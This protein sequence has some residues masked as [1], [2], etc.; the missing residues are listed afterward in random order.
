MY[1]YSEN[2]NRDII[3]KFP[4]LRE[5]ICYGNMLQEH[6][7]KVTWLRVP[8]W[9]KK[10]WNFLCSKRKMDTEE[11]QLTLLLHITPPPWWRERMKGD[12][13][14]NFPSHPFHC[15]ITPSLPLLLRSHDYSFFH[16]TSMCQALFYETMESE[17]SDGPCLV[18]LM[19]G[20]GG[21]LFTQPWC[22]RHQQRWYVGW[23]H[24]SRRPLLTAGSELNYKRR[25]AHL[26]AR[27]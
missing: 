21:M 4:S 10:W 16:S 6:I 23:T 7:I 19:L 17:S 25:L 12:D 14:G 22:C 18:E 8:K 27:V 2:V 24:L 15:W 5:K 26:L 13:G 20:G 11:Q 9:Y 1:I 3:V